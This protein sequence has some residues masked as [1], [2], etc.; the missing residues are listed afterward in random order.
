M[1]ATQTEASKIL[2]QSAMTDINILN[3][4]GYSKLRLSLKV[5]VTDIAHEIVNHPCYDVNWVYPDGK[6]FLNTFF[7]VEKI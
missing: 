1:L 2:L 5:D 3:N 7:F 6:C 4:D